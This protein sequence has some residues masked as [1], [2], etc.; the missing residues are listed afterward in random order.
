MDELTQ[1]TRPVYEFRPLPGFFRASFHRYADG[2]WVPDDGEYDLAFASVA[3]GSLCL[4][5]EHP[6]PANLR[7]SW[8]TTDWRGSIAEHP[9][10]NPWHYALC[11]GA[12]E[13]GKDWGRDRHPNS[14]AGRSGMNW[15]CAQA[16]CASG[17]HVEFHPFDPHIRAGLVRDRETKAILVP[18]DDLRC[19]YCGG[20]AVP[21]LSTK[22]SRHG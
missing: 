2:A 8:L 15:A 22:A 5:V 17:R 1:T 6:Y 21:A 12:S 19:V 11:D 7:W 13:F 18:P 9:R 4:Y 10:G 20:L 16:S 3:F 14:L